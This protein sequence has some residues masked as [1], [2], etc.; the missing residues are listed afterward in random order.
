MLKRER[1]ALLGKT[2]RKS[3]RKKE[4]KDIFESCCEEMEFRSSFKSGYFRCVAG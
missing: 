1:P 4:R 2:R 3:F